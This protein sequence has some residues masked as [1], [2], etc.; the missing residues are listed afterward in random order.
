MLQYEKVIPPTNQK[1]SDKECF[2]CMYKY[3][4]S[5]FTHDQSGFL[6]N[7][8]SDFNDKH[9][10]DMGDTTVVEVNGDKYRVWY[11]D[12]SL[13]EVCGKIW[14]QLKGLTKVC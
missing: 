11:V 7:G 6:C 14:I 10:F 3:P 2:D 1:E 8:C 4:A 5:S 9:V 13:E 12:I